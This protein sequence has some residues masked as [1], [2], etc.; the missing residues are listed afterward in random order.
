VKGFDAILRLFFL[1]VPLARRLFDTEVEALYKLGNHNQIPR[2]FDRFVEQQELYLVQEYIEGQDLTKELIPGKQLPE[3][4][5][6]KL[7]QELLEV[8]AFVHQHNI[9]HRDLKPSNLMRRAEDGK[10]VI[11]DFGAVKEISSTQ[12]QNN[13]KRTVM[14]GTTG[15]M[16]AE[17]LNGDP[18]LC[19]DV[20]AV[21][22]LG[23]QALTGIAPDR[24]PKNPQ[25]EVEWLDSI[26]VSPGFARV[27][28]SMVQENDR[29]RLSDASQALSALQ[30]LAPAPTVISG[31][32]RS[33]IAYKLII[34]VLGLIGLGASGLTIYLSYNQPEVAPTPEEQTCK[35]THVCGK[36]LENC[37]G[38]MENCEWR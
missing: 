23:I 18:K 37:E 29:V 33:P 3:T 26:K 20:Y 24:L 28:A 2:L 21:G 31:K 6:I 14:I 17:Q 11:I 19:S 36:M 12:L 13:Q 8:M 9:I 15:Y 25:G 22:M 32:T 30:A 38:K 4:E 1:K 10:I 35:N 34:L 5:V 16:P 27:L 7:L